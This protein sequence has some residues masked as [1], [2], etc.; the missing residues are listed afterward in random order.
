MANEALRG[1]P[2]I[3]RVEY[4]DDGYD[5]VLEDGDELVLAHYDTADWDAFAGLI[6]PQDHARADA[7]RYAA[8]VRR[9]LGLGASDREFRR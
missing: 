9:L 7:E 2:V 4:I 3:V 8:Q 6:D 5:V 1:M